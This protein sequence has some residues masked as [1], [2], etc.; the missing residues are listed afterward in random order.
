MTAKSWECFLMTARKPEFESTFA[1]ARSIE[2]FAPQKAVLLAC[3][4]AP[5][6]LTPILVLATIPDAK[7][8]N[9]ADADARILRIPNPAFT[10]PHLVR[11]LN[12]T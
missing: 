2:S 7:T 1:L 5:A 6:V 9:I 4:A 3:S 8:A 12:V 10:S 11:T